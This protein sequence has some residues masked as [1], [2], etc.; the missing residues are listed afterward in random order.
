[1]G[2]YTLHFVCQLDEPYGFP[3]GDQQQNAAIH[4]CYV[5]FLYLQS[6]SVPVS[7]LYSA[8]NN[9][10]YYCYYMIYSV[11]LLFH[12][13]ISMKTSYERGPMQLCCPIGSDWSLIQF[14]SHVHLIGVTARHTSSFFYI[15][16][17]DKGSLCDLTLKCPSWWREPLGNCSLNGSV[18]MAK[19]GS[20]KQMAWS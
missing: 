18:I 14:Q 10:Y 3:P 4:Q 16:S 11:L 13:K 7:L 6:V 17:H 20:R 12:V 1:M 8:G 15:R 19:W 9:S 5:H 2:H